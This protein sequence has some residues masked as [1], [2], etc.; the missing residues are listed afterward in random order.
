[1]WW[2]LSDASLLLLIFQATD[3][4]PLLSFKVNSSTMIELLTQRWL[5][6]VLLLLCTIVHSQDPAAPKT[7]HTPRTPLPHDDPNAKLAIDVSSF[8]IAKPTTKSKNT[9]TNNHSSS[10]FFSPPSSPCKNC[11]PCRIPVS[12]KPWR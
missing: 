6:A 2:A 8:L 9:H 11:S 7:T 1:M 4:N 3:A 10:C 5:T 12:T